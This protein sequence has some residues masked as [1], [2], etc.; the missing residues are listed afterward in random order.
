M[1]SREEQRCQRIG[2]ILRSIKEVKKSGKELDV[3]KLIATC[4]IEWGAARRTIMEMIKL[5]LK[6]LEN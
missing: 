2:I 5:C 6:S 4:A 3:E 1:N